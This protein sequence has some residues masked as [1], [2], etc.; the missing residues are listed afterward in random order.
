VK[1]DFSKY[2]QSYKQITEQKLY[3]LVLFVHRYN[4]L[5]RR[6]LLYFYWHINIYYTWYLQMI[7]WL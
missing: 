1:A 3:E 7:C 5:Q 4:M 6:Q 2:K